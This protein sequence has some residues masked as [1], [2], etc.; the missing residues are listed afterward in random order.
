M[1]KVI[2]GKGNRNLLYAGLDSLNCFVCTCV[3]LLAFH[4]LDIFNAFMAIFLV[5]FVR[6]SFFLLIYLWLISC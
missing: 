1:I 2:A 6:W 5:S 3:C 4:F